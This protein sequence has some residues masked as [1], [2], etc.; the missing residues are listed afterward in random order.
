MTFRGMHRPRANSFR[1]PAETPANPRPQER[2]PDKNY[3]NLQKAMAKQSKDYPP[4]STKHVPFATLAYIF[5]LVSRQL[6]WIVRASL[7]SCCNRLHR[8]VT[9]RRLFPVGWRPTRTR[10]HYRFVDQ[11]DGTIEADRSA[12]AKIV[13]HGIEPISPVVFANI[14]GSLRIHLL[15]QSLNVRVFRPTSLQ[16]FDSFL[17]GRVGEKLLH[18]RE[19][20]SERKLKSVR[21]RCRRA[22]DYCCRDSP[23]CRISSARLQIPLSDLTACG[24]HARNPA[25]SPGQP[26]RSSLAMLF[27]QM[28]LPREV[29][30]RN[31]VVTRMHY[32]K[33]YQYS[34][35]RI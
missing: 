23:L 2:D 1:V 4:Q 27:H 34:F 29:A 8:R 14:F 3:A 15:E 24:Q 11:C 17:Y 7:L 16:G 5:F 21:E 35:L 26:N 9:Y 30:A 31:A 22:C 12:D 6:V 18:P 19:A 25:V 13:E 33:K 32:R 28:H 20:V 10:E